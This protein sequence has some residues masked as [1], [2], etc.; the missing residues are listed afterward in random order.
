MTFI[1]MLRDES[2]ASA[3]EY[4]LILAIVGTAIAVAAIGLGNSIAGA[5]NEAKDCINTP[6]ATNCD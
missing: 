6:S 5:M 1:N 3:A 4:A 2:G